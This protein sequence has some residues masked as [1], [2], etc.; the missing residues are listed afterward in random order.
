MLGAWPKRV[1]MSSPHSLIKGNHRLQGLTGQALNR[2][3]AC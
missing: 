1:Q 3:L 2:S